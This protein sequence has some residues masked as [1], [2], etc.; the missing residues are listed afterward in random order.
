MARIEYFNDPSAP[1]PNSIV[2]AVTA[3]VRDERRRVL[4]IRRTDNDLWALPGGAQDFGE[5][6]AE[7]VVRETLEETGIRVEVTGLV[8]V[9][10]DPRHVI[11]YSNGEVRQQ[12][13]LC[14]RAR[15]IDGSPT[16]SSE[17][18]DVRWVEPSELGSLVIHESMRLRIEHGYQ[19]RSTPYI[20]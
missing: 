7:T 2:V 9:Y 11:A 10:S 8:G 18:S 17:S 15:P 5:F 4:L 1:S 3:F 19:E 14:F 13:S 16:S 20:G 12:F 6:V